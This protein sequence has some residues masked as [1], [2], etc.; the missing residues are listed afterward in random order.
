MKKKKKKIKSFFIRNKGKIL[1]VGGCV[2][3]ITASFLKKENYD[4]KKRITKMS[5]ER[6]VDKNKVKV[7]Q[8][9]IKALQKELFNQDAYMK[10][11]FLKAPEMDI[12]SVPNNW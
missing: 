4:L 7:M 3:L 1:F 10:N 2:A 8:N 5:K 11:F 12:Q 6:I 9:K